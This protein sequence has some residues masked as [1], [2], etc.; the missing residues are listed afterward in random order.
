[1]NKEL[2]RLKDEL[3][4][5]RPVISFTRGISMEPLLHDKEKKN[6]THVLIQPVTEICKVGDMPLA[7]LS[8]G[9]YILHRIIRVEKEADKLFYVTRG[10]NCVGCEYVPQEA[11]V[12]VVS[13]IYYK[14]HK[15]V[16]VTDSGYLRYV[17][18]WMGLFPIRKCF[19]RCRGV[20]GRVC[21]K[22]KRILSIIN[23]NI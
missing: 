23:R 18:I 11:V 16:K 17:K 12:G 4:A 1:M 15:T 3:M 10:D 19:M 9:R 7:L 21:R 2:T 13:E 20:I 5:G 6:A 8:D 14:N 22:V